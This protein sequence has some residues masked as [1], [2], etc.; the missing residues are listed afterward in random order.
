MARFFNRL[1]IREIAIKY[2]Y[3]KDKPPNKIINTFHC[4]IIY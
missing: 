4:K 2:I 1:F 3:S